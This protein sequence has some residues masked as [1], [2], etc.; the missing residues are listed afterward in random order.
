[1]IRRHLLYALLP[2]IPRKKCDRYD[3]Q[4]VLR[5]KI[6]RERERDIYIERMKEMYERGREREIIII[7][8]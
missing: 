6:K 4:I 1:M 8:I 2:M 5:N 7:F 3:F